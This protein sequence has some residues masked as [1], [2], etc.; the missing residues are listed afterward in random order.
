MCWLTFADVEEMVY[1]SGCI[2]EAC[3]ERDAL[4]QCPH[5]SFPRNLQSKRRKAHVFVICKV[6]LMQQKVDKFSRLTF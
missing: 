6:G 5:P 2:I 4:Y 3:D 1:A